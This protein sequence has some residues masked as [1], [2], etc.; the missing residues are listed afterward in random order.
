MADRA[1]LPCSRYASRP[2]NTPLVK[3]NYAQGNL[4]GNPRITVEGEVRSLR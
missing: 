1:N 4:R 2:Y 3:V